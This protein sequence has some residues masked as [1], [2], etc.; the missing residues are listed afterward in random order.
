[1]V[2]VT[3]ALALLMALARPC[4][5]LLLLLML[6]VGGAGVQDQVAFRERAGRAIETLRGNLMSFGERVD[7]DRVKAG[8]RGGSRGSGHEALIA[9]CDG[10]QIKRAVLG[11]GELPDLALQRQQ[12]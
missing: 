9:G 10:A 6:I 7:L 4:S 5:V 2:A 11:P 12:V 8:N 1:M 3:P